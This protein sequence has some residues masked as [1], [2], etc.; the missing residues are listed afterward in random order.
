MKMPDTRQ[1]LWLLLAASGYLMLMASGFIFV[2]VSYL[3]SLSHE[4]FRYMCHQQPAR[5]FGLDEQTMAVCARCFGIYA[6]FFAASL[7]G[8]LAP[9]KFST[10]LRFALIV[11]AAAFLLNTA[12]VTGNFLGWWSNTAAT[13]F[14]A[15]LVAGMSLILIIYTAV[16]PKS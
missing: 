2:D 4:A 3:H 5:S 10:S 9:V 6:G 15:G 13:R 16:K 1:S 7:A 11:T 14:V 12:D 8:L